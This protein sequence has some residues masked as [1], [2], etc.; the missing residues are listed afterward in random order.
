ML[1]FD[2]GQSLRDLRSVSE[3]KCI[4]V[5][6]NCGLDEVAFHDSCLTCFAAY[7]SFTWLGTGLRSLLA[8]RKPAGAARLT[9]PSFD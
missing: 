2:Q 5:G 3:G 9:V 1:D 4:S 7:F 8:K 6:T